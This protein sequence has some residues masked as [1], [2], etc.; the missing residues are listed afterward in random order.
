MSYSCGKDSTLALHRM[1]AGGDH[2][3]ALLVMVN[4][5]FKRSYFHGADD[6]MLKQYEEALQIPMLMVP[7]QGHRYHLAMEE[8]LQQAKAMGAEIACFG[9][10]D[11]EGNR[12]WSEQRCKNV[13]L[14]AAFPLWH[15]GRKEN[16]QDLIE[17]GYRCLIKSVN[18][19]QLPKSILGK[20]LDA[21]IMDLMEQRGIDVCGENG[22]Y[23]TLVVDG[24][25]FHKPIAYTL[26]NVLDF[27]THSVI[28][29]DCMEMQ[30]E[31]HAFSL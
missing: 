31:H 20:V 13:G 11:I 29:I 6:K 7:T 30:R 28:E 15:R 23:H 26:G 4:E 3:V 17:L 18:G 9:D 25:I 16:V 1:L 2:G 22:E 21:E 19:T 10:I 12:A 24:P 5:D 8:A 14:D 27:G